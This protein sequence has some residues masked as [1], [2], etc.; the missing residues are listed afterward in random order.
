M[1]KKFTKAVEKAKS[2][3]WFTKQYL[4]S[5]EHWSK[6]GAYCRFSYAAAI[7]CQAYLFEDSVFQVWPF[8]NTL[9]GDV[10]K[11]QCLESKRAYH[12][13]TWLKGLSF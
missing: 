4:E 6:S 10:V 2:G 9:H 5:K 3:G 7:F 13:E 12:L 1:R 8:T 11:L